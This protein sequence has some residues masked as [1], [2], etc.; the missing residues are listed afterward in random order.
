MADSCWYRPCFVSSASNAPSFTY[1]G[2]QMSQPRLAPNRILKSKSADNSPNRIPKRDMMFN[3]C[4][5]QHRA[6]RNNM[7]EQSFHS[8][9]LRAIPNERPASSLPFPQLPNNTYRDARTSS[10]WQ[11]GG[12]QSSEM[13]T[14]PSYV[15]N[16]GLY[17]PQYVMA[18][19]S[20]QPQTQTPFQHYHL[21]IPNRN[22]V[23][24]MES[25]S[26][27]SPTANYLTSPTEYGLSLPNETDS[28]ST[29]QTTYSTPNILPIQQFNNEPKTPPLIP[30]ANEQEEELVGVGLYDEPGL[31]LW[32]YDVDGYLRPARD[33]DSLIS[34]RGSRG[35]GLKLE[36]TFDPSAVKDSQSDNDDDNEGNQST[37]QEEDE[38]DSQETNHEEDH[39]QTPEDPKPLEKPMMQISHSPLEMPPP[40]IRQNESWVSPSQQQNLEDGPVYQLGLAGRSFFFENELDLGLRETKPTQQNMA[41][42]RNMVMQSYGGPGYGWV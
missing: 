38:D 39:I 13:L 31:P 24:I 15:T 30:D 41:F 20:N 27:D 11:D 32:D 5:G 16:N 42:P 7:R 34:L 28:E 14:S 9:L 23:N 2:N 26:S 40:Y 21:N 4:H 37:A 22:S 1:D 19:A 35:K 3:H 6:V 36:E 17:A 18:L 8:T 29:A 12:Y 33:E 10:T 25:L